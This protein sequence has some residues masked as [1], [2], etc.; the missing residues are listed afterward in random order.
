MPTRSTA[1][2]SS[3]M[4]VQR[5]RRPTPFLLSPFLLVLEFVRSDIRSTPLRTPRAFDI[6]IMVYPLADPRNTLELAE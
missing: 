3:T 6:D 2:V 4:L 5:N 1:S